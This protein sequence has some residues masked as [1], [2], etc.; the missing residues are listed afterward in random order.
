M[1]ENGEIFNIVNTKNKEKIKQ[2]KTVS[3]VYRMPLQN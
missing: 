1:G 2:R 3:I